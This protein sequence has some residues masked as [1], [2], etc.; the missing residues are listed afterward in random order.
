MVANVCPDTCGTFGLP[1]QSDTDRKLRET[2][3]DSIAPV[4][5]NRVQAIIGHWGLDVRSVT[6]GE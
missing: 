5:S 3:L 2:R 1:K 4:S 6:D